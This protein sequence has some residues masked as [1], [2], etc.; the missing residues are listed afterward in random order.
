MSVLKAHLALD[1]VLRVDLD[2]AGEAWLIE[3]DPDW[4]IKVTAVGAS[5][6]PINVALLDRPDLFARQRKEAGIEEPPVRPIP[7]LLHCPD[8]GE[9][10]ID[11]GKWADKVHHTH[12]CQICGMT[13]RPAVVAT[14]GVQF[15]PGFKDT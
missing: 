14:V 15:L 9:R 1:G 6:I 7:L 4:G 12:S 3:K 11:K 10:H 8:C 2:G 13:W 5:R